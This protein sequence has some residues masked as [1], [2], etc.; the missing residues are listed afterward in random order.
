M[1]R[2]ATPSWRFFGLRTCFVT[3]INT[4]RGMAMGS[5]M[6]VPEDVLFEDIASDLDLPASKH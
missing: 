6:N 3:A 4:S 5:N 2:A 1:N